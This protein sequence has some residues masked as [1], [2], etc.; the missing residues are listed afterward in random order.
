M[1]YKVFLATIPFLSTLAPVCST[2]LP[3][4]LTVFA[5][6]MS[7]NPYRPKND[8]HSGSAVETKEIHFDEAIRV[9]SF[10]VL[11]DD[12]QEHPWEQRKKSVASMIRFHHADLIGLQEPSREQLVDLGQ[13]LPE[14]ESFAGIHNPIFFRKSRFQL[15]DSGSFYLSL[16]PNQPS[17]GWDAKFPRTLSWVR[18]LDKKM[19][20]ELFF[21]NTHFDYHGLSART[22]SAHLLKQKVSEIATNKP[23]IIAGDFNLFPDLEGESTYQILTETFSDAIESTQFPHHGPTGTWSGFKEAG[24]PGIRPDCIFVSPN[25]EVYLHGILSDTF[26]GH[27]PSDHLPVVADLAIPK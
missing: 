12:N 8:S 7:E 2:T 1:F 9:M 17:L 22:Q 27:F 11:A 26:D 19:G 21:F 5:S 14:Y 24:Q 4:N 25:V 13:M 3:A 16:T 15:M 20:Q 10:N 18:L 6:M 23:F